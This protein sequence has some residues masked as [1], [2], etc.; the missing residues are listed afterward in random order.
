MNNARVQAILLVLAIAI[1]VARIVDTYHVFNATLDEPVH[2][3]S[4]IEWLEF[5]RLTVN[6]MHPPLSRGPSSRPARILHGVR[7]QNKPDFRD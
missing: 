7:W 2:L 5:S 1:G 4:G 6:Q 3:E